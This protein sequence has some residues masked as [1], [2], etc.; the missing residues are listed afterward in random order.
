MS[1][2]LIGFL[3]TP[4]ENVDVVKGA[5]TIIICHG[6]MSDPKNGPGEKLR[7]GKFAWKSEYEHIPFHLYFILFKCLLPTIQLEKVVKKICAPGQK[8]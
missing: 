7:E 5:D 1:Q 8:F 3:D 6:F 4:W 2:Q